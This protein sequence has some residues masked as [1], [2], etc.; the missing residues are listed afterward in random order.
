[1]QDTE[2]RSV[3]PTENDVLCG[4]G[5]VS[6]QHEGN[7]SF[8]F[9]IAYHI[10]NYQKAQ[11]KKDKMI[12][13]NHITHLI[14]KRGGRFL[15][16]QGSTPLWYAMGL[17]DSR[18]KVGHSLRDAAKGKIKCVKAL[19]EAIDK[20]KVRS[21]FPNPSRT[22]DVAYEEMNK[23]D[24]NS[25]SREPS[26]LRTVSSENNLLL[27]MKLL[28]ERGDPLG[29]EVSTKSLA[30]STIEARRSESVKTTPLEKIWDEHCGPS[31]S[32]A[33]Y[34]APPGLASTNEI[35]RLDRHAGATCGPSHAQAEQSAL[36]HV[37]VS[38]DEQAR[39]PRLSPRTL[40]E[41]LDPAL[42]IQNDSRMHVRDQL[43]SQR[44][45]LA[46][47]SMVVQEEGGISCSLPLLNMNF[48]SGSEENSS[49]A[50]DIFNNIDLCELESGAPTSPY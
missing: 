4:R 18:R 17:R 45:S 13:V 26:S 47:E 11:T 24:S 21:E 2:S 38:A 43:P 28:Q 14:F 44:S 48:I 30:K 5:T 37:L 31:A 16:P 49:G 39:S 22:G 19:S 8:R 23:R 50:L 3:I 36:D 35:N 34:M 25:P 6:F 15:R 10:P 12:L 29:P 46:L 20:H 7:Q 1:M 32:R 9:L 33:T 40:T 41:M 27:S 42:M